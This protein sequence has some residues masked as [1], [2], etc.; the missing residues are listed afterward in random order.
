MVLSLECHLIVISRTVDG[1]KIGYFINYTGFVVHFF[2]G[3]CHDELTSFW[4]RS[5]EY[6]GNASCIC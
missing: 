1:P 6:K 2:P 5:G 3:F 4:N